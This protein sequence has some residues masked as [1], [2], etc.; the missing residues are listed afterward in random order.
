MDLSK[1]LG[2]TSL[3]SSTT[4]LY[5]LTNL[6]HN[7]PRRLHTTAT[8]QFCFFAGQETTFAVGT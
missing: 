6:C 4:D 8:L 7:V 3:L 5:S 2:L 1:L